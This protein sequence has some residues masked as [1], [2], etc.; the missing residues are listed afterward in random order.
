MANNDVLTSKG[1]SIALH[2]TIYSTTWQCENCEVIE[3]SEGR[4]GGSSRVLDSDSLGFSTFWGFT[5]SLR[6]KP[7]LL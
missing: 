2:L 5:A 6:A 1:V 4:V 7:L 3:A